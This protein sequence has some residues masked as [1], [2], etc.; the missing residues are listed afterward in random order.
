MTAPDCWC[1]GRVTIEEGSPTCLD[2][3]FH[4]PHATG[5]PEVIRRLYVAGPIS[6]YPLNNYPEFHRVADLLRGVGFEVVNPAE[7]G[8]PGAGRVHYTDLLRQDLVDMMTCDGVAVIDLWWESSGARN[9]VQVAGI[10]RMP[11]HHYETWL[12]TPPGDS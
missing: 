3:A 6:G 11:V 7:T 8:V 9:E 5:R 4:D 10:L 1:G 2:S 12:R